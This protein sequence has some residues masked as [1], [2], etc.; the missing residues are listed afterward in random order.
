MNEGKVVIDEMARGC[1]LMR[2]RLISRVMTS[3]YEDAL[4]P[5]GIGAPQF[6]LLV[7]ISQLEPASRAEIGRF[8]HQDRSTLTRNLK[9]V[10]DEGWAEENRD[11]VKGRS[12]PVVLT[13]KGR[14]LLLAVD[15][16]MAAVSDEG[17]GSARRAREPSRHDDRRR[18]PER[19]GS[20]DVYS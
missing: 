17:R 12:R 2:T 9:L 3:L 1:L 15:P 8:H 16:G 11:K 5:F 18:H 14:D 13:K 20:V 6:V 4:R 19:T 7:V 10:F